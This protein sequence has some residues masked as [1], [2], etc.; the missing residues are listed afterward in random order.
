MK[1]I[2][3]VV[4]IFGLLLFS[5]CTGKESSETATSYGGDTN[6]DISSDTSTEDTPEIKED[7][8]SP[9][10][11]EETSNKEL[12]EELLTTVKT[13]S[14]FTMSDN[15]DEDA[16]DD[17]TIVYPDLQDAQGE[18]VEF[19]D[20][21]LKADIEVWTSKYDDS[22]NT[23]KDRLVYSGTSSIDNWEDGNMF[24][25]G[26]IKVPY[27]DINTVESD[28]E[29]GILYIKIYLPDGRVLEAKDE[30]IRIKQPPE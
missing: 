14:V 20:Y 11:V 29:Y 18:T 3:F 28:S 13:L 7:N 5:G 2:F 19:E 4:L 1:S 25:E 17:G 12:Q 23:V 10:V 15:W 16:A 27:S 9:P 26:G 24:M 30:F 22:Y 6:A 21:E 8:T